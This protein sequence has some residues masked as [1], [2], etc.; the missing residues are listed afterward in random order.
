VRRLAFGTAIATFCR[1]SAIGFSF[2]SFA[3]V[4][5]LLGPDAYGMFA[6]GF[7]AAMLLA[8]LSQFGQSQAIL[9]YWP[10]AKQIGGDAGARFVFYRSSTVV[11]LTSSIVLI[12]FILVFGIIIRGINYIDVGLEFIVAVA[13]FGF[14]W[15]TSEFLSSALRAQGKVI[16]SLFPREVIWRGATV[17]LLMGCIVINIEIDESAI[18][19]L[20]SIGLLSIVTMQHMFSVKNE[21]M[22][23]EK[24][25]LTSDYNW[26]K[27]SIWLTIAAIIESAFNYSDTLLIGFLLTNA[28]VAIYFTTIKLS[29]LSI[30]ILVAVNFIVAPALSSAFAAANT[31]VA[32]RLLAYSALV[33]FGSAALI[34][35]VLVLGAEHFFALFGLNPTGPQY[36]LTAALIGFWVDALT[37]S[38]RV[39][40]LITGLEQM[41]TYTIGASILISSILIVILVP[42]HGLFAAVM[43]N[44]AVRAAG[45]LVIW[46]EVRRQKGLDVSILSVWRVV[47]E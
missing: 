32:Q 20:F 39:V 23:W 37:G 14:A 28:D 46:Y 43:I 5:Q 44:S 1:L 7:S 47:S 19:V 30:I 3:L 22:S 2:V 21:P 9:R 16:V 18:L 15:S 17:L 6:T 33:G 4:A 26:F 34:S 25:Y 29:S 40:A 12:L 38:T 35:L 8:A 24:R 13:V 42:T 36:L 27:V 41:Y 31:A 10:A 11:L 45:N